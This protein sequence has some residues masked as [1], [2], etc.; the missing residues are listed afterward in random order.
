MNSSDFLPLLL[1]AALKSVLILLLAVSLHWLFP[2]AAAATRHLFL[3]IA[4]CACLCLPLLALALPTWHLPLFAAPQTTLALAHPLVNSP[5]SK[6]TYAPQLDEFTFE[7]S[8][9]VKKTEAVP[10]SLD[11]SLLGLVLWALGAWVVLA[12]MLVGTV[13]VWL[14]KYKAQPLA[15]ASWQA[16]LAETAHALGCKR[17]VSLFVSQDAAMPMTIG[18]FKPLVLLPTDALQWSRE[19]LTTVLWHELAHI[20]RRDCLTQLLASLTCTLYWF[21]PLT[22]VAARQLRT[23]REQACDDEVLAAGARASAYASCLVGVAKSVNGASYSSPVAVGMACSHLEDRVQ[24][25]LNPTRQRRVLSRRY[26]VMI[27]LLIASLI[28]PLASFQPFAQAQAPAPQVAPQRQEARSAEQKAEAAMPPQSIE[29]H[30]Q[31]IERHLRE[32][33]KHQ[34]ALTEAQR[35]EVAQRLRELEL[36]QGTHLSAIEQQ[37][38]A[39]E[40]DRA[41]RESQQAIG[42]KAE[43]EARFRAIE[44]QLRA[45]RATIGAQAGAQDEALLRLKRAELEAALHRLHTEY[46]EAHPAIQETRAQLETL[47]RMVERDV[48]SR[49]QSEVQ[50]NLLLRLAEFEAHLQT[51]QRTYTEKHPRVQEVKAQCEALKKELE[52][53]HK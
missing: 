5:F 50:T 1:D 19:Q 27:T 26:V 45:E 40:L 16:L 46:K 51:L 43:A 41:A 6:V 53:L 15:S 10:T 38:L 39:A 24:S 29:Q 30:Q 25:I 22:W 49:F 11:W 35:Q 48:H 32:I 34:R 9:R 12:Q 36:T 31:E 8:V 7:S 42:E 4:V 37:R 18:I 17:K 3:V 14:M 20:K 23:D 47:N 44:E 52:H 28:V 21:N 13:L 33:E 2:Q